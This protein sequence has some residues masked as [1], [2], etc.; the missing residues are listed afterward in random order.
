MRIQ[1]EVLDTFKT[2]IAVG[3]WQP[4]GGKLQLPASPP[5]FFN[6]RRRWS[7]P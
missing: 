2:T 1:N 5:T 6:T 7:Y 3:N 4:S